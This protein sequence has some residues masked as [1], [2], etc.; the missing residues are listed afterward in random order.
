ML[1]PFRQDCDLQ[2]VEMSG[3]HSRRMSSAFQAAYQLASVQQILISIV[4]LLRMMGRTDKISL[5][6]RT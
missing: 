3:E 6:N 1:D 2:S 4:G 5:H